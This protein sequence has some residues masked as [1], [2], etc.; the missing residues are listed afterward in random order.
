MAQTIEGVNFNPNSLRDQ[1]RYGK[2]KGLLKK[3]LPIG[4]RTTVIRGR[5]TGGYVKRLTFRFTPSNAKFINPYTFLGLAIYCRQTEATATIDPTIDQ[6]ILESDI[7]AD[8]EKLMFMVHVKF[9]QRN[10]EFHMGK[11]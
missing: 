2:I 3:T 8:T 9:D 1:M 11:V 7:T 4:W 10:P 6:S 5:T